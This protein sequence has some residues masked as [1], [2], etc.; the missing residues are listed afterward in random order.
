MSFMGDREM[1]KILFILTAALLLLG[2]AGPLW[3]GESRSA[4]G[5]TITITIRLFEDDPVFEYIIERNKRHKKGDH[6]LCV[7][8]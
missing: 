2:C 1:K 7:G 8:Y 6:S 4:D 3:D 5:E